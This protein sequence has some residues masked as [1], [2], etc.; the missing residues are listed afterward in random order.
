[1]SVTW[2]GID[3]FLRGLDEFADDVARLP[4]QVEAGEV[5]A[6][7]MRA[8]AP[9]RTGEL[10]DSV[11]VVEDGDTV[12]VVPTARHAAPIIAGVPS[13]N[14]DPHPFPEAALAA[15]EGDVLALLE[16]GVEASVRR[17]GL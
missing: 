3:G 11:R 8:G 6:D 2:H 1:M 17:A 14:I 7:A 9:Y 15:R 10:A 12:A 5:V 13:R 4:E 16:A